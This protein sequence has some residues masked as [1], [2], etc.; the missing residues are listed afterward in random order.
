VDLAMGYGIKPVISSCFEVGPGFMALLKMAA[1]TEG[2]SASGLDTLKYLEGSL[3]SR[4]VV[5]ENG[6][7]NIAKVSMATDVD[8]EF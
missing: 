5:I 7:I 3:F 2:D 8:Q 6:F 1:S 4:A